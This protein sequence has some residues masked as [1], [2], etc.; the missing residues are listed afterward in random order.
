MPIHNRTRPS[1]RLRLAVAGLVV[2]AAAVGGWADSHRAAGTA[3][4]GAQ[5]VTG[6]L[7]V[8]AGPSSSTED[9]SGLRPLSGV[10]AALVPGRQS[11][12][13]IPWTSDVGVCAVAV[14]VAADGAIVTYPW[15]TRDFS[16]FYREDRLAASGK[17]Y[18][19]V[20][21]LLPAATSG[22]TVTADVTAR[23]TTESS[24]S[25]SA[26]PGTCAGGATT[27]TYRVTL[28]VRAARA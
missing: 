23:F 20:R 17:D 1:L 24:T 13:E 2:A 16:S 25:S 14:T 6:T 12:V 15:T 11:W 3:A 18:T 22:S 27:R 9:A 5:P 4:A 19:A 10:V 28:P 7:E 8:Q 26:S 21:V